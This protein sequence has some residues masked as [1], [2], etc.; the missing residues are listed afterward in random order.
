MMGPR[1]PGSLRLCASVLACALA[2]VAAAPS[3]AA[4]GGFFSRRPVPP[5]Q[6]PTLSREKV[7]IVHDA[8]RSREHFIREVAF[9][10]ADE[11]FGFVVPTPSL[12][13]VAKVDSTPFTKLRQQFAFAAPQAASGSGGGR[14]SGTG[15][16][17][18]GGGMQVLAVEKVGSFTAF[19]LAATDAGALAGW[20]KKNGLVSTPEA[21]LWLEHYVRMGFYYVAM[22]YDPPSDATKRRSAAIEAETLRISFD[23]PVAYYPYFEPEAKHSTTAPRLLE[24]WYV[25]SHP[26]VPVA[27]YTQEGRPARWVRPM[28]A[29]QDDRDARQKLSETLDPQLAALLPAGPL[30]VQTFQDQKRRRTGF[31]DVLFASTQRRLDPETRQKLEPLLAVL[32]GAL[33]S[34]A[35]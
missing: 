17:G 10:R 20:L 4:C 9:R 26:V 1:I 29:G 19:T 31:K 8:A 33:A 35:K 6:R 21:D 14:G 5:E 3:A 11:R 25:G 16:G 22:R 30:V 23:T 15:F 28:Q 12:P 18:R 13:E 34:E 32:D 27:E 2:F 24:V 7:L